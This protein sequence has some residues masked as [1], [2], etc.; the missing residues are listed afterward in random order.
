[1]TITDETKYGRHRYAADSNSTR[2]AHDR[3]LPILLFGSAG[4]ITW[5]IRGTTGWGG[6][7]GTIVPGLTWGLLWYYLCLRKGIDAREV[8]LWLGMGIGLGGELGYGQYVSWIQGKF[9]VSDTVVPISPAFGYVWFAI[10][11]VGWGAPGGIVLGWVLD[12]DATAAR[13]AL[14]VFLMCI[15]F[16][17]LFNL[18]APLL[19]VGAIDWIGDRVA[20]SYPGLLFPNAHLGAYGGE[21]DKHLART[22]Y[23]NTQNAAVLIWWAA[24]MTV[25]AIQRDRATLVC[26]GIIGGGFGLGFMLSAIW[27]LGYI[28][29]P[30]YIDWWKMWELNAGFNLGLLYA[31]AMFWAVRRVDRFHDSRDTQIQSD[32]LNTPKRT[33]NTTVFMAISGSVLIFVAG[34]E[35]FFWTGLLLSLFYAF[36]L[37]V[38]AW[39]A[40]G[41]S[42]NPARARECRKAILLAFSVFLLLFLLV[43]GAT[44]RAGIVL[45]FYDEHA[46]DQY[47]WPA[48]RIALFVPAVAV[49]VIATLMGMKNVLRNTVETSKPDERQS[50]VPER[51]LDLL[52]FIAFVGV[53]TIWPEKIGILYTLFLCVAVFAFTRLNRRFDKIDAQFDSYQS[54]IRT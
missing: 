32:T 8:V 14:R 52:A 40:G 42:D 6:I 25:A 48:P 37:L 23:T 35:Y 22:V 47:A 4:A 34:F 3:L 53:L 27:C 36:A 29:A 26:G 45:G 19:G 1:M 33:W 18:G 51:M 17:L 49:V 31:I 43:H 39:I 5:A 12:E 41:S 44:S 9:H 16:V 28:Y 2:F 24:A 38:S 21:L 15:L 30:T 46:A 11:G 7:D 20:Q 13:W 54:N 10:C 50:R